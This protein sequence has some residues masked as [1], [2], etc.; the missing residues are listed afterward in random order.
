M[1]VAV[2]CKNIVRYDPQQGKYLHCGHEFT[3]RDDLAGQ[4]VRC[5]KCQQTVTAPQATARV[6]AEANVAS[7]Q[8]E[9]PRA[10]TAPRTMPKEPPRRAEPPPEP[11]GADLT[12]NE[13]DYPEV[14]DEEDDGFRLAP[15]V[16]LPKRDFTSAGL[17]EME[18]PPPLPPA[19]P[20]AQV[21]PTRLPVSPV[22]P[23]PDVADERAPCP[24]CGRPLL[25]RSVICP[26]CGYHKGLQRR[27]DAFEESNEEDQP[28]G[29]ERWLRRQLI[30]GDD[31]HAIRSVLVVAG[32]LLVA[33]GAMLFLI[34]GH[35][36]WLFVAAAGVIT[37]GAWLGWWKLDPWRW[38]LF[39]N[40]M[41]QWRSPV[42]PFAYR[43]V[44]D[45]RNMQLT[46]NELGNLQN[47][48]EFEVIDLEGTPVTDA[49]L[50]TLY[51]YRN[52]QFIIL[53]DTQTTS[54]GAADLQ[55][56]LPNAWIWR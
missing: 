21:R 25:A 19:E 55:Q 18:K 53:R 30:E 31:P 32:L 12:M 5:P 49:G 47:L 9:P 15:P 41:I 56:A 23:S 10:S 6:A 44:L 4:K 38:M 36:V 35:T 51:D 42:P 14:L 39:A 46:D 37:A 52:L 16:E 50:P 27:V 33:L 17:P 8:R 7:E 1:S 45:L 48:S 43:K 40:R 22:L 20:V 34:I 54:Q 26:S 11:Q 13:A 3:V 2:R 28:T 29:F 24:G